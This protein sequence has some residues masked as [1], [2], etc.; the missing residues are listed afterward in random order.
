MN[1]LKNITSSQLF[2]ITSLNSIS[3][4]IKIGI[5]LITSK[6]LAVFVGPSGMA[7]V[8]NL[9]N[10]LTSVESVSTLGF[11]NGIVKYVAENE[12]D[13]LQFKKIFSTLFFSLLAVTVVVSSVLFLF[14]YYWNQI[15][16]GSNLD[17][18]YVFKVLAI[19]L[20]L[21]V[22]SIYLVAIINGLGRFKRVININII[23]NI[24]GLFVTL[25]F[26]WKWLVLGALLAIIITPSLLFFVTVYYISEEI[27]IRNTINLNLFDFKIIKNLSHYF[28]MA[29]VSGI[30]GPIVF[31]AIRHQVIATVGLKEAG[32]WEAMTRIST[33]YLLFV[34]TLLTVYYYP[35]LVQAKTNEETKLVFWSFYKNVLSFFAVGLFIIYLL[36]GII[37]KTL[38]TQDFEPVSDLFLWQL[39]GDF[40]KAASWILGFQFFAKKMTKA[41]IITEIVSLLILYFS[42]IYLITVFKTEGVV[43][44]HAFTYG[45][46]LLVLAIYFRKSLVN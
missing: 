45:M 2:K 9:R 31:L 17:Y 21:Y 15:V 41:F 26:I 46:Y 43:M 40:L 23:G 42:S 16:F 32:F 36:R 6:V 30:F 4:L 18:S 1:F 28:L 34:N 14:A 7:L 10:F 37:I 39:V 35:K 3:V 13:H 24:I 19:A 44:A 29:L 33:Y 20:P 38:F 22:S 8:G 27:S 11:Q 12:E 25:F 5:G